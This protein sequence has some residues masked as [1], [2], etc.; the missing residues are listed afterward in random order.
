MSEL[1]ELRRRVDR[2]E[3]R[4]EIDELV[5]AYAI[6]CDEHDVPRLISLFTEDAELDSPSGV[7]VARGRAAIEQ[8]FIGVFRS[9]GPAYHWTHDHFVRF[10]DGEPDVATGL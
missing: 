6:A 9:R 2:L 4:N 3:S 7:I 5:S 1:E 10:D 8:V